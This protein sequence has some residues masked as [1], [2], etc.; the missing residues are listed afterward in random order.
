MQVLP[1]ALALSPADREAALTQVRG[2][3]RSIPDFPAPGILFRDITPVLHDAAAL[4]AAVRLHLDLI[5]DLH[6]QIDRIVGIESRGFLFGMAVAHAL[7]AGFVPV[8][9]PGKLPAPTVHQTY[10]LEY[11][12]DRLHMHADAVS[13]GDRVLIIDDLLATGGTAQAAAQLV[14]GLGGRVVAC[15]FLIEL[16]ALGGRDRLGDRRVESVIV[17]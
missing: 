6:G 15:L 17:Y 12:Q 16:A 4:D 10:A 8:R 9:K 2:L 14:E 3:V 13:P 5:D 1:R 7:G 11:G